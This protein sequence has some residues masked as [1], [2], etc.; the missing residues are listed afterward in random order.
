MPLGVTEDLGPSL[1]LLGIYFSDHGYSCPLWASVS[2]PVSQ[3]CRWG[4]SLKAGMVLRFEFGI[5]AQP[6][7]PLG[8]IQCPLML[9][10]PSGHHCFICVV[11]PARQ[12][13]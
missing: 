12:G 5:V 3:Q 8:S 9:A 1:I 13:S 4:K 11:R 7:G 2:I 10:Q 6:S